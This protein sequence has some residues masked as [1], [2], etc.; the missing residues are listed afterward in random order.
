MLPDMSDVLTEWAV[1]V[2]LKTLT[3]TT[4]DFEPTVA[5]GTATISAVCQPTEMRV[6]QAAQIDTSVEHWTFHSATE[7]GI[8]QFIEH[9][10]KDYRIVRM[11]AWGEY[12]Y[13]EGVGERVR[14]NIE[15]L[16]P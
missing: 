14:G 1:P 12:G 11:M 6:L 7:F 16:A 9:L 10:G 13:W 8:G 2:T 5:V 15:D 4:V 3:K